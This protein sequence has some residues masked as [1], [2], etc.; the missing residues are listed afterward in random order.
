MSACLRHPAHPVKFGTIEV[1]GT[2]YLHTFCV[3]AFLT[4]FEVIAII[5][6]ILIKLPIVYF[7]NL[8]AD[9]V[10]EITV[11]RHHEQAEI[12]TAEIFFEPFGHIQIKVV[13]RLIKNQQVRFGN[14]GVSQGDTF[15]LSAGEL[16]HFLVEVTDFELGKDLLGFLFI[17]PCL[18]LVHTHQKLI[19]SGMSIGF[20]TTFVLL[21]QFHGTV[22]VMKTSLKDG[23]FFRILRVLLQIIDTKVTTENYISVIISFFACDDIQ[24]GCFSGTVLGDQSHTLAF[25]N[26]KRYIFKKNQ[27]TE[28]LGQVVYL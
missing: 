11:V 27:V 28:G 12:G 24:Q 21:Y 10:E 20:H 14:Q 7:D 16:L 2:F 5:P 25:G 19:Q 9:T 1:I 3:D 23:Q 18:L 22:A 8:R 13:G 15:Q 4:F 26:A 17:F 6:F